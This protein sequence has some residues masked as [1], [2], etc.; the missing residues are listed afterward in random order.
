MYNVFYIRSFDYESNTVTSEG[1]FEGMS[2]EEVMEQ[3][4]WDAGLIQQYQDLLLTN[5]MM[6]YIPEMVK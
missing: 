2:Y 6:A 3:A 1:A 5:Q 4:T